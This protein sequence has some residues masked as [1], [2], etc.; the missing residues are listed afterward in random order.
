[1]FWNLGILPGLKNPFGDIN[2]INLIRLNLSL[3]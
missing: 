1:M 2:L 3:L